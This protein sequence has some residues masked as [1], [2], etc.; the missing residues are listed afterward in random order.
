M[1]RILCVVIKLL[2]YLYN[3]LASC[4]TL[5]GLLLILLFLIGIRPYAVQTGSMEPEIETGSLC[6]VNQNIPYD[7]I[8]ENDIIAFRIKGNLLV[9]H[10]VYQITPE[11][12]VTKGDANNTEDASVITEQEYIGK[13][14]YWIPK[15]GYVM[16]FLHT[17]RGMFFGIC[18]FLIF[19]LIGFLFHDDDDDNRNGGEMHGT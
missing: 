11:G 14:V 16:M 4:I 10:R 5:T 18:V 7:T 6:F 2:R 9:T 3:I 12:F 15:I 17:R 1:Q 13:T 19:I 8:H